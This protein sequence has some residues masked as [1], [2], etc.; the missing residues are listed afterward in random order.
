MRKIITQTA[1][2]AAF[3]VFAVGLTASAAQARQRELVY[4]PVTVCSVVTF[5]DIV[6]FEHNCVTEES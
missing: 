1:A 5:F 2:L 3:V 4:G 6:I